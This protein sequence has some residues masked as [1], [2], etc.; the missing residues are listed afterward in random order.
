MKSKRFKEQ[1]I[2]NAKK[3]VEAQKQKLSAYFEEW[4]GTHEQLDDVCII[5]VK[6]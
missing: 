4:K 6:I 2:M 5:G 1:L 3:D